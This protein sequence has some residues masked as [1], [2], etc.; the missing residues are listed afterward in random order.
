MFVIGTAGHVDHGKSALVQAL[1]GI[2]PDRLREEKERGMTIDLGFA[3]VKLPS[4]REVS[5]VDV[6]GHERF[7]KNMLAGVGGIDLAMLVI[8]AD[9]G[10]MPQTREHLAI[11]DLLG[12]ARGV[13]V[14]TKADLVDADWLDLVAADAAGLIAP[15]SLAGAPIVGCSAMTGAGL[16]DLRR[17]LDTLLDATEPRRD[18]GR[19]RLPIDRAFT[20]GGFGTVVTGTLVDGSLKVGQ[21]VELLPGGKRARIRGLQSHGTKVEAL[22]PGVRCAANLA[23]IAVD[24]VRRG[25]VA[26][27]PGWLRPS[28]AVDAPLRALA[29]NARPLR[30]GLRLSFHSGAAESNATL[31]LLDR[32]ELTPGSEGWAQLRL[33]EPLAIVRGDAFVLRTSNDTVGGG[34]IVDTH[35]RR[36]RRNHPPTLEALERLRQNSPAEVVFELLARAEPATAAR[37]AQGTELTPANVAV[38]LGELA[39]EGRV[40]AA[41]TRGEFVTQPGLEQVAARVAALLQATHRD[42]PLRPG[43]SPDELRTRVGMGA[44]E[45]AAILAALVQSGAVVDRHPLLAAPG[46]E[47][48]P[49]EQDGRAAQH[50]VA[51]LEAAGAMPPTDALPDAEMLAYLEHTGRV[52]RVAEGVVFGARA[53]DAIEAQVVGALK[54]AGTITLAEV[55]DLL[56]TSRK[57]AQALLEYLDEKRITARRGDVRVLRSPERR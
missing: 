48:A 37:L 34:R 55:R 33:D 6:P 8:A 16:D 28:L 24:E 42:F 57:Y 19:P 20:I 47:P 11:L 38:A 1:T 14:L 31:R 35:P 43:V 39:A 53:Y 5:L 26:T 9:E 21:E 17:A 51:S 27:A 54:E 46:F 45:F 13:V 36:H 10:V 7:I 22:P 4:G 41:G 15:T 44:R 56:G 3:W 40:V 50:F 23:G 52:V 12:V 18:L 25:M 30:H 2:D 29:S 49:G 32:D